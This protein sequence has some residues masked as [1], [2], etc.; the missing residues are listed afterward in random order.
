MG[1]FPQTYNDHYPKWCCEGNLCET[2]LPIFILTP[3]K[4]KNLAVKNIA[5]VTGES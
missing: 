5:F 1:S 3:Y 4:V 2:K